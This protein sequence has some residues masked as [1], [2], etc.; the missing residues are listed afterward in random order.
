MLQRYTIRLGD[1][2]ILK[3]DPDGLQRL[4]QGRP[5][6]GTDHRDPG[7]A[8]ASGLPGGGAVRGSIGAGAR[9]PRGPPDAAT[10]SPET[11]PR[12]PVELSVGAPPMVQALAEEPTAFV[13]PWRE[14]PEPAQEVSIRLK[15]LEY[16]APART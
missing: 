3:V 6:V 4:A 1:G 12:P 11:P 5:G 15:P 9:S 10:L 13:P 8:S 7:V 16:E 2:T 14:S